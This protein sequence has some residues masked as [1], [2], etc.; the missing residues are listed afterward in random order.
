[1]MIRP[2]PLVTW[3]TI[4]PAA[5][6][7]ILGLSLFTSTVHDDSYIS[8]WAAH[9][10]AEKGQL[11]NYNGERVEQS[12]SLAFVVLVALLS[13][14]LPF[15]I[16]NIGPLVSILAGIGTVLL[17]QRIA[18]AVNP[19]LEFPAGMLAA[20]SSALVYWSFSGMETSL[21][22]F[23]GA[24]L[25]LTYLRVLREDANRMSYMSACGATLL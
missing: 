15:A 23:L 4:V 6:L 7:L 21:A 5:A 17:V 3:R 13:R 19:A 2:T 10:L 16:S 22:A 1:M 9:T 11:V 14:I 20:S 18:V 8:Y 12:S 25:L 24:W